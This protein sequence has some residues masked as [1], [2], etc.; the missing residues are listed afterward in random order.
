MVMNMKST[1]ET[2]PEPIPPD[3]RVQCD[4]CG[5]IAP[6]MEFDKVHGN[7]GCCKA[8]TFAG[9]IIIGAFLAVTLIAVV[10]GLASA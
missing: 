6:K 9:Y 8:A 3:N 7:K 5:Y 1:T 10:S 2:P 4:C